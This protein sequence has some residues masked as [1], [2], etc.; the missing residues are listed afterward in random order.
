MKKLLYKYHLLWADGFKWY[1]TKGI[2]KGYE[3]HFVFAGLTI[4]Q[5]M[6]L[7]IVSLYALFFELRI[8]FLEFE[9][10]PQL[11]KII[12]FIIIYILPFALFN[13]YFVVMSKDFKQ[14]L[15]KYNNLNGEKYRFSIRLMLYTMTSLLLLAVFLSNNGL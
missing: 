11:L 2:F 10:L 15:L 4:F 7:F 8:S 14:I 9:F 12:L 1:E 13:I 6:L 3:M 5:G